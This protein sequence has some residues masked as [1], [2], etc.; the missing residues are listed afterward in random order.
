MPELISVTRIV[1]RAKKGGPR[2]S[3]APNSRFKTEDYPMISVDEWKGMMQGEHP[4]VRHPD[5][6]A[7]ATPKQVAAAAAEEVTEGRSPRTDLASQA[8]RAAV[9]EAGADDDDD[10]DD[11]APQPKARRGRGKGRRRAI[12]DDDEV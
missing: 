8:A 10:D 4:V 9:R 7:F 11:D 6:P 12:P 3:I 1:T 2:I 5:D